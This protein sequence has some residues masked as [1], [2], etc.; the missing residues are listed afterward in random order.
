MAVEDWGATDQPPLEH[1]LAYLRTSDVAVFLVAWRYGYIPA[2][3]QYSIT[4]LEYRAAR[5]AGVACLVF[6]T[7]DH[8]P[9]PQKYFDDDAANI[10]RFRQQLLEDQLVA[11]FDTPDVLAAQ[12]A[13]SLHQWVASGARQLSPTP[14]DAVIALSYW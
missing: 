5:E 10:S 1:S 11:F 12:V 8:A 3:E 13:S 7:A 9:W 4:E 14:P 6:I 2:S